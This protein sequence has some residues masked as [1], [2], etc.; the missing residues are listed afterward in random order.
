MADDE[1]EE[2]AEPVV[3]LGEGSHVEGA[4]L[5]RVASRSTWGIEKSRLVERE[6]DTEIR[7]PDGP[8]RLGDVL[9]SV[10][11]VYFTRR[12]D[13]RDAIE[14]VLGTGPVPTADEDSGDGADDGAN[15]GTDAEADESDPESGFDFDPESDDVEASSATASGP[16][17]DG[18]DAGAGESERSGQSDRSDRSDRSDE[19]DGTGETED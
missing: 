8:Q 17:T 11:A 5:A 19:T 9:G 14:G 2:A 16:T 7:T 18:S 10:D 13:F 4:P 6:G 1:D 12:Q 3:E 15:D